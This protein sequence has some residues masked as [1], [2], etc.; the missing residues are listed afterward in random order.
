MS[1][2]NKIINWVKSQFIENEEEYDYQE[3]EATVQ[4]GALPAH[5]I[6]PLEVKILEPKIYADARNAVDELQNGKVVIVILQDNISSEDAG[7][8]VDFMSGA[9]YFEK[10]T[11]EYFS[12]RILIC[13]PSSVRMQKDE[14]HRYSDIPVW[15]GADE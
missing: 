15:K 7:K 4:A 8:F 2:I 1:F 13:A 14:L 6:R 10:G 5:T 11:V 9:V 3:K 12:D